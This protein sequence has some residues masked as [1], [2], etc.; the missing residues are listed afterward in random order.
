M[1]Y[2]NFAVELSA[3][4]DGRF[5]IAVA[6]PV[7]EAI[8]D[9]VNPFTP[10]EITD[11]LQILGR[12][13]A[14]V[15]KAQMQETARAFGDRLFAFLIQSNRDINNAYF[16]SLAHVGIDG[17]RIR[18]SVERAGA[19]SHL[20]WELLRDPAREYIALSRSTPIVR[21]TQ[22]LSIRPPV[23]I[24]LPLRVL[25]MISSP[26]DFP[27]LDVEGEW[28]R[29]QEASQ[30]L[31]TR[32]MIQLERLDDAT[33]LEL[34]RKLRT[35]EYHVFH[36]I[37]HSDFDRAS[38]QG[39][40]VFE[41]PTNLSKGQII[42][43]AALARE[44]S[45]ESTLRLVILN[46]CRSARRV[47][48]DP[49]AGVASSLVARGIP[50][51][52]AMQFEITDR[53]AKAFAEE[54][55]RA[56]SELLPI[57][58]AISEARRAI[59]NVVQNTEWA[60]PVLYMRSESGVLFQTSETSAVPTQPVINAPAVPPRS[61]NLTWLALIGGFAAVLIMLLLLLNS[62]TPIFVQPTPTV[63]ATL[64]PSITPTSPPSSTP[65]P[66]DPASL[67][68]LQI[69]R[70]RISP[71][72]IAPGQFFRVNITIT[73]AG[74]SP[75]GPFAW[76]WDSNLTG[77]SVDLDTIVQQVDNIQPGSSRSVSF[78]WLYGWW[79]R[80]TTQV[81]VDVDDD[82]QESNS[83]NN[84][85][86][87]NV[88]IQELPFNIDF[89][90]LPDTTI[91][92]PP[93]MLGS[94]EFT[95]WNLLFNLAAPQSD[96]CFATPLQLIDVAGDI[97]LTPADDISANCAAL[98]LSITV[99]RRFV[100]DAQVFVT[101]QQAGDATITYFSDAA[102]TQRIASSNAVALN[103]GDVVMLGGVG[104]TGAEIRRIHVQMS[105]QPVQITR[106]VLSPPPTLG[107]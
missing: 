81:Q 28:T 97:V 17:L 72:T 34:Q 60:T 76:S 79:G 24:T 93:V 56:L 39:V 10:D 11:A 80:Y 89:T 59:A 94:D 51:V 61:R 78:E 92:E 91:V 68:D 103:P 44:I 27:A 8:A 3:L 14:D 107:D 20:P 9:V 83:R 77:T 71:E 75:S 102:G 26:K 21:Y 100:S 43:G 2:Q 54:F 90:L 74:S 62:I 99:T 50:A 105:G 70:F 33:L 84:E 40:L 4:P 52:V 98:P 32:G 95:A 106:L 87:F 64:T 85:L 18:L 5:R 29:L 55:Y 36:F 23:P 37:G 104:L 46:S 45:E 82:V 31:Q 7:G 65:T 57:D 58:S 41:D 30:D 48:A 13:R 49:F 67:P 96:P 15:T 1:K 63:T 35:A 16:A 86:I 12:E 69:T 22:Q 38:N 6:S 42:S 19:L 101:A 73:N 53:A 66:R 25:V 88:N 47:D